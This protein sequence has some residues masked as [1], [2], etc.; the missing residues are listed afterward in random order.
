MTQGSGSGIPQPEQDGSGA[1]AQPEGEHEQ[2]TNHESATKAGGPEPNAVGPVSAAASGAKVAKT[3]I[4]Q[5][6]ESEPVKNVV[7]Q[8]E[9]TSDRNTSAGSSQSNPPMMNREAESAP[10]SIEPS[11]KAP[12]VMKTMLDHAVLRDTVA[13]VASELEVKVAEQLKE[14]ANEPVKPFVAIEKFKPATPCSAVWDKSSEQDRFQYCAQCQLHVYDFSGIELPE[15]EELILKRENRKNVQLFKR[16]DGKFLT[17]DC[18]VAVKRKQT[19]LF[20]KIGGVL[21]VLCVL[22]L[23]L[24]LPKQ[25][26][27]VAD[28]DRF[29]Q[30][31]KFA[32]SRPDRS[33]SSERAPSLQP[34]A[35]AAQPGAPVL[36]EPSKSAAA[37]SST[38]EPGQSEKY[39]ES[40][41]SEGQ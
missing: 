17:S 41:S 31:S 30:N 19:L 21:L 33:A 1:Y 2:T 28:D 7:S 10:A 35:P 6:L 40:Q 13:K 38:L 3:L 15:A 37:N 12:R 5:P 39:W 29:A 8:S 36:F 22:A 11:K 34:P 9:A 20:A 32:E 14:R 24:M 25:A 23:L 27:T 18:P 4:D 26:P 16:V